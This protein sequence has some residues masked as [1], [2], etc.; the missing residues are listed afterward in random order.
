MKKFFREFK[1]F[2]SRGNVIDM[3]VGVIIGGAFSAIVTA[4]ANK[5]IMPLINYLL[6]LGGNGLDSAY[7]FLKVAYD[8]TGAIDLTKSIFIDWGAFI[9]AIIDFLLI[10]LIL[11]IIIKAAMSAQGFVTKTTESRPTKEEKKALKE[12]GVDMKNY[13]E[14]L[15]AT[16]ALREERRL[17]AEAEAKAKEEATVT[18]EKLLVEIR[19]LLANNSTSKKPAKAEAS[20][21]VKPAAKKKSAKK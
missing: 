21:E 10:A 8:E 20:E 3:A 15:A 16:K 19:D 18:T 17:A 11:F 9:T 5:I 6:A 4:L 7:T 1:Q 2:I 12:K 14:V 13:S